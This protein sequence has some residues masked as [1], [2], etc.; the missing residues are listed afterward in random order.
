YNNGAMSRWVSTWQEGDLAEWRG[1]I[2]Q[3]DHTPNKF[4]HLVLVAAGT[5]IA[6]MISIIQHVLNN[7]VDETRVHLVFCCRSSSDV[8]CRS[9]IRDFT[10]YW[11][12]SVTYFLTQDTQENSSMRQRDKV[13]YSRLS[14]E[15]LRRE[16]PENLNQTRVVVCGTRSFDKDMMNY[17]ALSGFPPDCVHKF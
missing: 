2:G 5:G 1:P 6:P 4:Q 12:F 15:L 14:R 8:L 17:L 7:D 3:F 9:L 11:N 16:L 10:D 13:V